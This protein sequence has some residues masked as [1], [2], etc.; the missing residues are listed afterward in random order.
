MMV[1]VLILNWTQKF[2]PV[3]AVEV[4]WALVTRLMLTNVF[5]VKGLQVD[6]VRQVSTL[7]FPN[8]ILLSFYDSAYNTF[9]G[10]A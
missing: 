1:S 3:Q 8:A 2:C 10:T 9:F 7:I 6:F 4:D 5:A